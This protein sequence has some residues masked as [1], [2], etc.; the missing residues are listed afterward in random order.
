MN[1]SPIEFAACTILAKNY[2]PM[3]RTLAESWRQFHSDSPLFVLFLDSPYRFFTPEAEAFDC[4]EVSQLDIPNL[5]GFLFKYTILEASTA[6]KPYFLQY[7][8][9]K[10]SIRK[11]LYLDP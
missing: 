4:I 9:R 3:A 10:Y 11:L 6:V 8:F 7:L 5:D 1:R 2:L